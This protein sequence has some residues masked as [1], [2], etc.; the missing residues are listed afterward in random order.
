MPFHSIHVNLQILTHLVLSTSGS[1]PTDH[2]SYI[3][4]SCKALSLQVIKPLPLLI[5]KPA[6]TPLPTSFHHLNH[7]QNQT[8]TKQLF[9][10]QELSFQVNSDLCFFFFLLA[11]LQCFLTILNYPLYL[12]RD[13]ST[14]TEFLWARNYFLLLHQV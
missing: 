2:L 11:L 9:N 5:F 7:Y 14:L 8:K 4:G 3:V 1:C 13:L 10:S 12:S 6:P